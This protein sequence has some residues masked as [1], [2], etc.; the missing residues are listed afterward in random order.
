MTPSTFSTNGTT[1]GAS[2]YD[3]DLDVL[4]A[5]MPPQTPPAT[6]PEAVFSLTLKGRLD[7]Q[8]ALLT[9]RGQTPAE[10]KRNLEAIRGL[11]DAP[12][13]APA[14]ASSTAEGWC[15][16]HGVQMTQT[17]KDGRSWFS[18]RMADGQ[19]CKGK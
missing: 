9:A 6:C 16:K 13:Q 4:Y 8:E 7:G 14:Q 2:S 17:T 1:P 19:W 11:L 3:A 18:H 15:R 5:W 10:F 12:T